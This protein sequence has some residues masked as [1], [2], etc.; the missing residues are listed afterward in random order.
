MVGYIKEQIEKSREKREKKIG[1]AGKER[2][3]YES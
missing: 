2:I 1:R 3:A